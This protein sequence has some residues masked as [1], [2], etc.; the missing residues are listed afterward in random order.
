MIQ[1]RHDYFTALCDECGDEIGEAHSFQG[2]VDSVKAEGG[3][4]RPDGSGWTHLCSDCSRADRVK[5]Q[6]DLLGL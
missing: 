4:V 1:G 6:R 3:I 5:A 2:A